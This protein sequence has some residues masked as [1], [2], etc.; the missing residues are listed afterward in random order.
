MSVTTLRE[1]Q[2]EQLRNA[3]LDAVVNE[4]E[5]KPVDDISMGDVAQAAG[6]SLRTLY[7][8]FPDRP[9]LLHAA[10]ERLYE[11]MGVPY[12]VT[13]A[14]DV[15]ASFL[16]AAERLAQRPALARA[17]VQTT[18]GR[19]AR[20]AT[21]SRRVAAIREALNPVTEGLDAEHAREASAVIA[22]LCSAASWVGIAQDSPVDDRGAQRGVAWAIDAL[23][24]TL[25]RE[26]RSAGR[27]PSRRR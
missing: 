6:I 17:L 3:V 16:A 7:R 25:E 1:R 2:A 24:A 12:E 23:I 18:A 8:C 13:S 5:T 10:G 20:S 22:Y 14:S 21:R 11:T 26:P 27:G 9:A 19:A 15:S 4:L